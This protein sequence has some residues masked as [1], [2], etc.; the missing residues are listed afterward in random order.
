[1]TP[2]PI[3]NDRVGGAR[4]DERQTGK[5]TAPPESGFDHVARPVKTAM[6][7]PSLWKPKSGFVRPAKAGAFSGRQS[8]QGN[9]QKPCSLDSREERNRG[10]EA[11]RQKPP[12]GW[13]ASHRAAAEANADVASK[14]RSPEGPTCETGVKAAW[15]R[16]T[17]ANVPA[18]FGG[19]GSGGTVTRTR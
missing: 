10:P 19:V 8:R 1:V 6:E 9:S 16:H 12:S 14:E 7:M 18:H 11:Y 5:G 2:R 15:E 4:N 17:L 3:V 13:R